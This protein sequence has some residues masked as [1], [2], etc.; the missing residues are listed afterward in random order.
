MTTEAS[1]AWTSDG[2]IYFP[3]FAD[4]MR[5]SHDSLE[6]FLDYGG[7]L[8]QWGR[9]NTD[10]GLV[11]AYSTITDSDSTLQKQ[12]LSGSGWAMTKSGSGEERWSPVDL[13]GYL[14]LTPVYIFESGSWRY[15]SDVG[16]LPKY[17]N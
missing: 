10:T 5:E 3:N 8:C 15:A 4:R 2:S 7:V 9:P 13:E 16:D 14:G 6:A 1:V 11:L 17:A 12:Q